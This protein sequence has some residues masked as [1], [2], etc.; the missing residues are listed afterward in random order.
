MKEEEN[1]PEQV[2]L[3]QTQDL[4]YVNMKRTIETRRIQR[5][6]VITSTVDSVLGD[7]PGIVGACSDERGSQLQNGQ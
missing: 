3:M 6:Q 7:L 4:K 2:K 1:T 5:L